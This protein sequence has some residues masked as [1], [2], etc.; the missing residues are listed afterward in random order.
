MS[1]LTKEINNLLQTFKKL[2]DPSQGCP[3]DKE[4]DFKSIASCSIEEAYE[5]A[6]AIEREDFNDL[7]E[8]LGDLFF[9]I[10]FHSGMAEE[11]KLFNF[12]EVVKELNDK[13]IRR[14]PHVFDKKQEM[15]ASESLEIWEKEKKKER[16]KKNLLSL[17]DDIPKNLPSLT[18]AKKIQKRAKSVGFDWQNESDV[19]KKIDEEIDELKR[20]KVSQKKEDI[21]EEIGDLFF[22]LVN[23]SR[24][25]NL[26]P[27][28]IIRKANLKFEKRF[29]KM[30]D[31][32]NK[33]KVNLEDLEINEL[34]TLWQK[35]K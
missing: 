4:Q 30:E 17:M 3:W 7:K 15:S 24:H 5:V 16:E 33:T 25:Y 29:R 31:E 8:E 10:I 18:R 26:E 28:D 32:A 19:I 21:S 34:E 2:R 20:A 12:E 6:D 13:L 11:K 27:E 23:L 9:Q 14:H 35:I 1:K 22:T